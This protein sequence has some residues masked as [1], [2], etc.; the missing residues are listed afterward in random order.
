MQYGHR[1]LRRL[2]VLR[3]R[4]VRMQSLPELPRTAVWLLRHL[5]LPHAGVLG[6]GL[7]PELRKRHSALQLATADLM[8][9]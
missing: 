4:H 1:L 6:W 9:P 3:N 8:L 7:H 5:L 2:R